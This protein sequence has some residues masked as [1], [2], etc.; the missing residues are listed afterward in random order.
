MI[1]F[2]E[3]SEAHLQAATSLLNVRLYIGKAP[4]QYESICLITQ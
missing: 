3:G 1:G 2:C 4:G